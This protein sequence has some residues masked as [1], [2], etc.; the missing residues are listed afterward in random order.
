MHYP[1]TAYIEAALELARYDKLEDGTFA[2]EIPRLPGVVAFG[3]SLRACQHELRSV[4]ED[5]ILVGLRHG[6]R[7][8]ILSGVSLNRRVHARVATHQTA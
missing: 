5:W 6:H 1:L 3:N 8:P 7:I 4:L 2:A